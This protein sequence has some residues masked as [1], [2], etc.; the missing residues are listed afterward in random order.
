[1]GYIGEGLTFAPC[2]IK[3]VVLSQS[4][5]NLVGIY[6]KHHPVKRLKLQRFVMHVDYFDPVSYTHLDVYKRQELALVIWIRQNGVVCAST[7]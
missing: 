6:I 3:I 5:K 2:I 4:F 7:I 1:M